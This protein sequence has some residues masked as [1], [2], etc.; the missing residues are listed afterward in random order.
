LIQR[1]LATSSR[2]ELLK[3]AFLLAVE[4]RVYDETELSLMT[5]L[6]SDLLNLTVLSSISASNL[7]H[8]VNLRGLDL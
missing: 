6:D 2:R 4:R 8:G 1:V 5:R 3:K 7:F